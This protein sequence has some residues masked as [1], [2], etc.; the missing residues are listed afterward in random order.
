M[1]Q[2]EIE[3]RRH[4]LVL[5]TLFG[6]AHPALLGGAVENREVE[7]LVGRVERREQ[8]EHRIG[9]FG[10]AGV[11]AVHLVDHDDGLEPHLQ[12]LRDHEFGLRQR[13]LGGVDQDQR[14][15]HHIEDALD[16]AA[17]IGVARRVDD[18]D[19][20]VLPDQRGRL[21]EDGN[22]ALA[23]EVVGIHCPLGDALIVAERAGLLQ[24]AVDQG[25]FAMVDMGNDG[26]V[27]QVHNWYPG[28]KGGPQAPWTRRMGARFCGPYIGLFTPE[29][30]EVCAEHNS[31]RVKDSVGGGIARA[32]S[33]AALSGPPQ[34]AE[35]FPGLTLR[36]SGNPASRPQERP[37]RPSGRGASTLAW[38]LT[39]AIPGAASPTWRRHGRESPSAAS[40]RRSGAG[41]ARR[42]TT[43]APSRRIPRARSDG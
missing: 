40:R 9:D 19:A 2:Y 25:G 3:Q 5:G 12:G 33:L 36:R 27:A 39:G 14:A 32:A 38:E 11:G 35:W 1:A 17:E 31:A 29:A 21:G 24:K 18:I 26:D 7:L 42:K 41:R 43:S 30:I 4:A 37:A 23:F 34:A 10:G 13:A 15:I 22:A 6:G 16:L 28:I 8:V 20:G